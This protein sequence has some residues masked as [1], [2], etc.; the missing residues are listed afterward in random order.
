MAMQIV[1]IRSSAYKYATGAVKGMSS[2]DD[3]FKEK[4]DSVK[5]NSQ[6]YASL[7]TPMFERRP[8]IDV[9]RLNR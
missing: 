1:Q 3:I 2:C 5:E 6:R 8:D 9:I 7:A 4:L